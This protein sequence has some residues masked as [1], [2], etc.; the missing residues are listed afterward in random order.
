MLRIYVSCHNYG[1]FIE[2]CLASVARQSVRDFFC[3]VVDD[4][5]TDESYLRACA[6]IATD[7]RFRVLRQSNNGQLSLFNRAAEEAEPDDLVFFLDADDIWADNHLAIVS[8][9]MHGPLSGCDFVFTEKRDVPQTFQFHALVENDASVQVLGT[10]S[11][12]TRGFYAWIGN[13]TSTICMR[14]R[15][16]SR[17]L[18]YPY[19]T[20]WMVRADDC[21]VLGASVVNAVKGHIEAVTVQ[22]RVHGNN[23]FHGKCTKESQSYQVGRER[24]VNWLSD[25]ESLNRIPSFQIVLAEL[26]SARQWLPYTAA[27]FSPKWALVMPWPMIKRIEVCLAIAHARFT[28][29]RLP[30]RGL[31]GQNG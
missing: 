15:L 27:D 14:G 9:A 4:G 6:A 13:V 29:R 28:C 22:Y 21:L 12:V 25:R 31:R 24:F 19:M 1:L 10:T 26:R 18:P 16:L 20:E 11:G 7:S 23:N 3:T 2:S 17:I 8:A 30:V 5:S